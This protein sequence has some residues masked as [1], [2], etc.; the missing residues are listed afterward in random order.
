MCHPS[1]KNYCREMCYSRYWKWYRK[2]NPRAQRVL[3]LKSHYGLTQE[4]YNALVEKQ[5]G[6]CAICKG[7]SRVSELHPLYIGH[8]H[9]TEKVRGLPCNVCN[10]MVGYIEKHGHLLDGAREY[11]ARQES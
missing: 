8:N 11:L 9:K 1:R 6:V 5:G 7:K 3:Y 10:S 4:G 2:Q